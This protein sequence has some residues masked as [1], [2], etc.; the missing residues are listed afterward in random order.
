MRARGLRMVL[1]V[2]AVML[3]LLAI[4]AVAK[5]GHEL[6]ELRQR[7]IEHLAP[8]AE[9]G[10]DSIESYLWGY[11]YSTMAT[12][13]RVYHGSP[14]AHAVYLLHHD[15][16]SPAL[17]RTLLLCEARRCF[18]WCY[19]YQNVKNHDLR[20][21]LIE[22]CLRDFPDD[23]K[24]HWAAGQLALASGDF[25]LAERELARTLELANETAGGLPSFCRETGITEQHLRGRYVCALTLMGRWDEADE[26]SALAKA[27]GDG[28]AAPPLDTFD[29]Y[30]QE[31][32][33]QNNP[34]QYARLQATKLAE[35]Q[36]KI[37][38]RLE[39][40]DYLRSGD[41]SALSRIESEL[42][43]ID[44]LIEQSDSNYELQLQADELRSALLRAHLLAHDWSQVV[45]LLSIQSDPTESYP[46]ESYQLRPLIGLLLTRLAAG[47]SLGRTAE[48]NRAARL[49]ELVS[50]RID[51]QVERWWDWDLAYEHRG[52]LS[53]LLAADYLPFL[54][55]T[56]G[57]A[58]A[59]KQ[60]G[61]PLD[62]VLAEI[63]AVV[64]P[65]RDNYFDSSNGKLRW[66]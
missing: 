37:Q 17:R 55:R 54:L 46:V 38:V 18:D 16:D 22:H 39:I 56:D 64:Q 35:Q 2:W 14:Q 9:H 20:S 51:Q 44:K 25:K 66:H 4:T 52:E 31:H 11:S 62:E 36:R 29:D 23:P 28:A 63:R 10:S 21:A 32:L 41:A 65:R 59:L 57:F 26:Q 27:A 40:D 34:D 49:A 58:D 8:V 19:L 15:Y 30:Y 53:G 6:R 43:S 60:S 7:I 45:A 5:R 12:Q 24:V 61:R 50:S 3:V 47:E 42:A 13:P 48:E 1:L 33:R